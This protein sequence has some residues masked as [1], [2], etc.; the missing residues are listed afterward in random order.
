[1]RELWQTGYMHNR[2]RMIV[3]SFLT[4]HLLIDW[5]E[6]EKWFWDTLVDA[7]PANNTAGWQ[8][9]AGSGADAS[10]YYRIF[11]P[12]IQGKKFDEQGEYVKTYVPELKDLD[13]KYIHAPW[14]TPEDVLNSISLELGK[15]YPEPIVDHSFARNRAL[16]AY[17]QMKQAA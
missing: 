11:N 1:M 14:E 3:A 12:I 16:E 10:P 8:W 5:R 13:A 17:G 6:G 7:D 9:V 2:V 4:K 15:D